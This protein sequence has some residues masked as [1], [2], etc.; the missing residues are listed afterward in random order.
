ME[1]EIVPKVSIITPSYNSEEFIKQTIDSVIKQTFQKWELIVIDDCSQDNTRE[2]VKAYEGI[3]NRI[4]LLE[5]EK[6]SGAA[7]ARNKGIE[8]A[9]GTYIAFLDSDDIWEYAKLEKQIKFMEEKDI[10]FSFCGYEIIDENGNS[11]GKEI[12]VPSKITYNELLGNTII[13]CLTVMLNKEKIGEIRMPNMKPEDTALWLE[14]LRTEFEAYGIQESLA[15]YRIVQ[16]S[17]SRNKFKAAWNYLKVLWGQ[18]DLNSVGKFWYFTL[19]AFNALKK[20]K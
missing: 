6:N 4:K 5:L 1:K 3:D 19:Y 18:K 13:G 2:I 11:L 7:V 10:A 9:R 8:I 12:K 16:G 20:N 15:K 17:V 14:I